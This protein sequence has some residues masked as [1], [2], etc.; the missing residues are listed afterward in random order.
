METNSF[1]GDFVLSWG[2]KI[3]EQRRRKIIHLKLNWILMPWNSKAV[4]KSK[5]KENDD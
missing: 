4:R 2:V 5:G 3:K 1:V